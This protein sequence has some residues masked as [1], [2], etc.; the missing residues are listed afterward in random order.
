MI[1][2]YPNKLHP[3][4]TS[5][6]RFNVIYGG[7]DSGKSHTIARILIFKALD[8]KCLILCTRFIQKSIAKS[9]YALL[10]KIINYYELQRYFDIVDNEIRCL[11]TGSKFIF[12]GLWQNIDN[13]RSLEGVNYCWCEE[14]RTI[15]H[16]SWKILIPT[17]RTEGSQ[18]YIS[19]NP[20]QVDDPV[21]DMF[22]THQR[23]DSLVIKINYYENPFLS[24]TSRKEIEYMKENKPDDYDWIYEGNIRATSEARILHNIIMHDFEIDKS[25][26]PLFGG[27]FGFQDANA[28]MQS[29]IYDNE[30]YI[31]NEYYSSQLS[32]DELR[33]QLIKIQ[34][35]LNQH[36]VCDSSQPAMIKM[37]NASGRFQASACR[38]SIGQPQKEGA[39]KFTMAL[40]LKTFKKIH[41]HETNC[42]NACRE[43]QRWSF[44]TDKND[45]VL[46]IVQDGDDHVCDAVIYSLERSGAQWYRTFMM[47]GETK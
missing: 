23:P 39:Y 41:I 45:K 3:L 12:E 35:L 28:F 22:V 31:C 19:F 9:S 34:W 1:I 38:K 20:D 24:E 11:R 16:D 26:Q 32:P 4:L 5:D 27:D 15:P 40:Y 44:Q 17:L 25:R 42:P 8:H 33:D 18:F 6:K 43:M 46:D 7:R 14:S 36:I 29:Y 47:K 37:L 21:Y 2:K 13:I 10:V 30:L